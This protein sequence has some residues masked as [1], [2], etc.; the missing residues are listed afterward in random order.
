M[1]RHRTDDHR[2]ALDL[3]ALQLGDAGQVDQF[4]GL[5]QALLQR[6]DQGLPAGHQLHLI[7]GGERLQ[8][9]VERGGAGIVEIVHDDV[10]V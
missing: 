4:A 3:D 2:I 8:R 6:R 1:R 7:A 5:R 10:L 9:L